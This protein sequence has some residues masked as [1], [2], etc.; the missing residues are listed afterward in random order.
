MKMSNEV[1]PHTGQMAINSE[2]TATTPVTAPM[3]MSLGLYSSTYLMPKKTGRMKVM[4][5]MRRIIMV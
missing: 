1:H 4:Y 2:T 3:G 5:R